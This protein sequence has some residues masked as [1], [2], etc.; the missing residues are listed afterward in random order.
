VQALA[1]RKA[2]RLT[3]SLAAALLALVLLGAA[4]LTAQM[5]GKS[6][7]EEVEVVVAVVDSMVVV[8]IRDV[9]EVGLSASLAPP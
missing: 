9:V 3:A 6:R 8:V 2:R 5:S 1:E 7:V 4:V